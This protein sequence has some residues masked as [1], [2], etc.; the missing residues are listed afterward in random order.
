MQEIV[1]SVIKDLRKRSGAE[2]PALFDL[3]GEI[4]ER[5]KATA[6]NSAMEIAARYADLP[7]PDPN[8]AGRL[9]LF[10]NFS[11]NSYDTANSAFRFSAAAAIWLLDQI[12][13]E[14]AIPYLPRAEAL[15]EQYT[16]IH[17]RHPSYAPELIAGVEYVLMN[18]NGPPELLPGG[19]FRCLSP[20]RA[21]GTPAGRESFEALMA[22]VPDE[23]IAA[24]DTRLERL[25]D[26]WTE[27]LYS[28]LRRL[29]LDGERCQQKQ[30]ESILRYNALCDE[31]D[32][33]LRELMPPA[34]PQKKCPVVLS[35]AQADTP[36]LP[37]ITQSFTEQRLRE[38]RVRSAS[39]LA[40]LGRARKACIDSRKELDSL[41]LNDGSFIASILNG[42]EAEDYALPALPIGDA[43][44]LSFAAFHLVTSGKE[45][46]LLYGPV[47]RIL[48]EASL[49]LPWR[50]KG[51][52]S[53]EA[54][55]LQEAYT[56]E[57]SAMPDWTERKYLCREA[58][59]EAP[60]SLAQ[61]IYEKTGCVL[62]RDMHRCDSLLPELKQR[63]LAG[64][65]A[66]FA[67]TAIC[68]LSEPDAQSPVWY[69]ED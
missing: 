69:A 64:T 13:A 66:A 41:P 50:F 30:T 21:E 24:A 31:L 4:L 47:I 2:A 28:G 45:R 62:P 36:E 53:E 29:A 61:L 8:L 68:L 63:G 10:L 55:A 19:F 56:G 67:L 32:A 46:A 16:G 20:L 37:A 34:R 15:P 51:R 23:A 54:A 6:L 58:K 42:T 1:R 3:K 11:L 52:G 12:D 5:R 27:Q 39:L 60:R 40:E 49:L 22:L 59:G 48:Q 25:I 65:D 18:W 17:I 7:D 57:P 26:Q 14:K 43:Y 9:W 33:H 35:S 38:L 44:E